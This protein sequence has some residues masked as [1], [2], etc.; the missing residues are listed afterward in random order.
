MA[1]I[2]I[3]LA[4]GKNLILTPG[5][6]NLN[7]PSWSPARTPSCSASGFATLEP[8]ARQRGHAASLACPGV[9]LSGVIFDAGPVNSPVLLQV[10]TAAGRPAAASRLI[11]P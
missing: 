11:R 8:A 1:T 2:N 6:Y 9:K 5:V 10:G 3:A 4:L 7:R